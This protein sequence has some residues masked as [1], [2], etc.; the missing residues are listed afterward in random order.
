MA[1]SKIREDFLRAATL[2]GLCGARSRRPFSASAGD[3]RP[4]R[5]SRR[6][7]FRGGRICARQAPTTD[8]QSFSKAVAQASRLRSRCRRPVCALHAPGPVDP[9]RDRPQTV[10]SAEPSSSVDTAEVSP[11]LLVQGADEA[12]PQ[13]TRPRSPSRGRR[14]EAALG[15]NWGPPKSAIPKS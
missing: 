11:T 10:N 7:A 8:P 2:L 9:F 14:H 12:G 13:R 15:S 3:S 4:A 6:R 5:W 1:D